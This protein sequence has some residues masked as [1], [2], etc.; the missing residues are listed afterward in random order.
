MTEDSPFKKDDKIKRI[1]T[2]NTYT[3]ISCE[4]LIK[5]RSGWSVL[6][7]NEKSVISG[8]SAFFERI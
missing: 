8:P 1:G 5:N 3:V 2:N 7:E 4:R 6:A